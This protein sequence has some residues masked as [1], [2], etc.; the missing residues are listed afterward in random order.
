MASVHVLEHFQNTQAG[1]EA[2]R[3][4][5]QLALAG[6][7]RAWVRSICREKHYLQQEVHGRAR[8]VSYLVLREEGSLLPDETFMATHRERVGILVFSRMK[9][10]RC[11]NWY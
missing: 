1:S 11:K 9:S 8:P 10:S 7:E 4:V 3:L 5:L 6:E 2:I